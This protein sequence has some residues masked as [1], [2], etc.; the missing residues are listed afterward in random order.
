MPELPRGTVTFLFTDIE[1]ST[2]M[3]QTHPDAM[4]T[5]YAWHD[6]ILRTAVEA[7]GGV[8]YKTIGD[9]F[10]VAFPTAPAAVG[11][12]QAAQIALMNED[13]S[14]QGLAESLRV[15]M[16]LHTGAVDP[17]PD[18][19]YRSPVLNR[20]GRLL[21]AGHGGQILLS[22]ATQELARDHLPAG[23]ILR[24][25]GEHRLK[26]LFRPEHVFQLI[27][28]GLPELSPTLR[29]LE[30]RPNN[31][32]L[33]PTPFI[34]REQDI[35]QIT[36]LLRRGD[37][38][39]LTLTGPGGI[40]KTRLGLQVSADLL[41]LYADG[42]F[43]VELAALVDPALVANAI[44]T[45]FG[46]REEA[47]TTTTEQL[48]IFLRDKQVLLVLDNFEQVLEAASLVGSL[49]TSCPNLKV[50]ITSRVRLG[51]R[52]ERDYP[53]SPLSL[54]NLRRLPSLEQ[55]AQY[56]AVRLFVERAVEAQPAFVVT[57]ANAPAIA[58]ICHRLD[59]LPLAIELAAARIRMLPPQAMLARL[60]S[61]LP[62]LIGGA[63]DLPPRQRTLRGAIAWS[64]EL[65]SPAEQA[66]FRRL[67]V[68]AGGFTL[69]AAEAVAAGEELGVDLFE[70]L[71]RLVEHS[72]V[73]Q[74]ETEG[75]PRFTM[76]ET[77]REYGQE[78][79]DSSGEAG[80]ADRRHAV[81]FLALA[82]DAEPQLEGSQQQLWLER[83]ETEHDNL[84]A[85]LGWALEHDHQMGL[86]LGAALG[87]FWATYAYLRE[88]SFWLE[89]MLAAAPPAL[90]VEAM[91][92]QARAQ[93][94]FC[95]L[96]WLQGA[97]TSARVVG[98]EALNL[99]RQVGDP[100]LIARILR[101]LG[102]ALADLGDLGAAASCYEESLLLYQQMEDRNGMAVSL[103]N[104]GTVYADL[105]KPQESVKYFEEGLG[106]ARTLGDKNLE[107]LLIL[108][109]AELARDFHGN[110]TLVAQRYHDALQPAWSGGDRIL[111]I[112]CLTGVAIFTQR[113]GDYIVAARLMGASGAHIEMMGVH[114]PSGEQ[115]KAE[116]ARQATRAHLGER[117]FIAAYEAG[118]A[119]S[120]EEAVSEALA[121][122]NEIAREGSD[123]K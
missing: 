52:G 17:D 34:G 58:E 86:Q 41:D 55:M 89:R 40:G 49:L 91:G 59:G 114:L 82:Q 68:F 74:T 105:G 104:L 37:V 81:F 51:L 50:L 72:L 60:Q 122:T 88:G 21:A 19:D 90:D 18:G 16:A 85:V 29:T 98:E 69:Q 100:S 28:F 80:E 23:V 3:W 48:R 39:L 26:D 66:L 73:R 115:A 62:L 119:L 27:G 43:V 36:A 120:L 1:G 107:G 79:L 70:G 8:V 78:Q 7:H 117:V 67:S 11:A 14:A 56:D 30:N 35:V 2:R 61:R 112:Y 99:A 63:R 77:I 108:N 118:R 111:T 32:P 57:N 103:N 25:L 87:T 5:A 46:L 110:P 116:E 96:L 13:W 44:S 33:Q 47:N 97:Y 95:S 31:L 20:L 10:Q 123:G 4:V 109:L 93:R 64:Y 94:H 45:V 83:L 22:Q 92:T 53:V 76:L 54:P 102:N 65:L 101:S 12:A 38:R 6:T 84:R 24:D 121:V 42:V 15:R 106:E 9:A 71:E 75:E 113:T